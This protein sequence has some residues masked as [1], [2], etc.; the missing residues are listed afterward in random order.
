MEVCIF[1]LSLIKES[2]TEEVSQFVM[3]Q[4]SIYY[5]NI[6]VYKQK[7]NT[8]ERLNLKQ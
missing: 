2:A 1:K 7:F 8:A 4:M 3:P 5:K 6:C